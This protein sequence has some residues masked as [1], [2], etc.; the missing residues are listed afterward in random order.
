ME[1]TEYTVS[2][3]TTS[4]R[5]HSTPQ[6]SSTKNPTTRSAL[7]SN[8][9]PMFALPVGSATHGVHVS[10]L[11]GRRSRWIPTVSGRTIRTP[12]CFPGP[13]GKILVHERTPTTPPTPH[14]PHQSC[15]RKFLRDVYRGTGPVGPLGTHELFFTTGQSTSGSTDL[16]PF[17]GLFPSVLGIHLRQ[18]GL[19]RG[20]F[21]S[22]PLP[23]TPTS[24]CPTCVGVHPPRGPLPRGSTHLEVH[25]P[26]GPPPKVYPSRGPPTSGFTHLGVH[27]PRGPPPQGVR[28]R[29]LPPWLDSGAGEGDVKY[30]S[31]LGSTNRKLFTV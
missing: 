31:P 18:G 27:P 23:S 15:H 4:V 26:R 29:G 1:E 13:C 24:G 6:T 11:F 14:V 10:T 30:F 5:P 20:Q 3:S 21:T 22:P 9:T 17:R 7:S 2:V 16:G 28:P 8:S 19:P 25:P 12:H